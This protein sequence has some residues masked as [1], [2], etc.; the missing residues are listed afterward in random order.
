MSWFDVL[1]YFPSARAEDQNKNYN[2]PT[3]IEQNPDGSYKNLPT[4]QEFQ[5]ETKRL[6][7]EARKAAADGNHEIAR[8]LSDLAKYNTQRMLNFYRNG[9]DTYTKRGM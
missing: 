4:Y 6:Q 1:K 7:D 2:L 9:P 3:K 5:A 8:S